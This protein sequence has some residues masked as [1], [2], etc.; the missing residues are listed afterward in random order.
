MWEDL[1]K[2]TESNNLI[3]V[4]DSPA[5]L[6]WTF[7]CELEFQSHVPQE[8]PRVQGLRKSNLGH[9]V[10]AKYVPRISISLLKAI[11]VVEYLFSSLSSNQGKCGVF[12]RLPRSEIQGLK[13]TVFIKKKPGCKQWGSGENRG[14]VCPMMVIK[15]SWMVLPSCFLSRVWSPAGNAPWDLHL[16][17]LPQQSGHF[18][19]NWLSH[20]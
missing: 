8:A 11:S 6:V 13:E 17:S 12:Q 18:W 10:K 20:K 15:T 14:A 5:I 2:F 1:G 4:P 7:D 19:L 3:P 9:V 16:T